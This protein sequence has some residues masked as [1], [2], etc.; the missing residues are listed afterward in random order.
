M[1]TASSPRCA[2]ARPQHR[3]QRDHLRR[4]SVCLLLLTPLAPASDYQKFSLNGPNWRYIKPESAVAL[5]YTVM[6]TALSRILGG[7]PFKLFIDNACGAIAA[8]ILARGE[9]RQAVPSD[10]DRVEVQRARQRL[11]RREGPPGDQNCRYD[12]LEQGPVQGSTMSPT[13]CCAGRDGCALVQT[14][15]YSIHR[16][17]PSHLLSRIWHCLRQ[18]MVLC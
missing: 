12:S 8:T 3:T 16:R 18:Q 5:S 10:P 13:Q 15:P 14:S 6:D 4:C 9:Y 2:T 17:L 7:G 11:L 1:K